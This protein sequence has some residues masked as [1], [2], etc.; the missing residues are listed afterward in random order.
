M[1]I[2][3]TFIGYQISYGGGS[4]VLKKMYNIKQQKWF[5]KTE[6]SF[7]LIIGIYK[8]K[9]KAQKALDMLTCPCVPEFIYFNKNGEQRHIYEL[10]KLTQ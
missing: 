9:K 1:G 10:E 4:A 3:I 8:T 7:E 2:E 6:K 5:K